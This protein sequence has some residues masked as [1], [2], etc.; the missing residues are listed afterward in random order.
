MSLGSPKAS[1]E[2]SVEDEVLSSYRSRF[3]SEN[4]K[5]R[6][7]MEAGRESSRSFLDAE[8]IPRRG[9]GEGVEER[10]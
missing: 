2:T 8:D 6:L 5:P 4:P 10:N 9:V 1:T 7:R 3:S